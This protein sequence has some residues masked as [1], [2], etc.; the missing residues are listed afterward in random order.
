M[1]SWPSYNEIVKTRS[2]QAFFSLLKTGKSFS[3][4]QIANHLHCSEKTVRNYIKEVNTPDTVILSANGLYY[5]DTAADIEETEKRFSKVT[6]SDAQLYIVQRVLQLP[7]GIDEDELLKELCISQKTLEKYIYDI[8]KSIVSFN[9]SIGHKKG[10]IILKGSENDKRELFKQNLRINDYSYIEKGLA[11]LSNGSNIDYDKLKNILRDCLNRYDIYVNDYSFLNILTHLVVKLVRISCG[12]EIGISDNGIEITEGREYE[13]SRDI[14]SSINENFHMN[15][16]DEEIRQLTVLISSKSIITDF[17]AYRNEFVTELETTK[18]FVMNVISEVEE[19][20]GISLYDDEF[21]YFFMIHVSGLINRSKM[22][23]YSSN[24]LFE[25]V[26]NSDSYIYEIAVFVSSKIIDHYAIEIPNEEIAFIAFHIGSVIVKK[27]LFAERIYLAVQTFDFYHYFDILKSKLDKMTSDSVKISYIDKNSI[28]SPL[29]Y[30]LFVYT[31]LS[32]LPDIAYQEKILINPMIN[33]DSIGVIISKIDTIREEKKK[34][35]IRTYLDQFFSYYLFEK[36]VYFGSREEC[37]H[38]MADKLNAAGIVDDNFEKDVLQREN[39]T[40]TS[41]DSGIALPHAITGTAKNNRAFVI[42]NNKPMP[43]GDY[44]V[45][46][47]IMIA[48]N[49]SG[50][51]GF[52]YILDTL[53]DKVS[54][55]KDIERLRNCQDFISFMEIIKDI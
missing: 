7:E 43:W 36:N 41:F 48:L 31:G 46:I 50:Y 1:F 3:V 12:N 51:K 15:I 38:Y 32:D 17:S 44:D 21:I 24:P 45:S 34:E 33:D 39:I 20:F 25:E 26:L 14:I 13:C 23:K 6:P 16:S 47:I 19:R 27:N 2:F 54:T 9:L 55:E 28:S 53:L 22:G 35:K 52:K 11:H 8:N 37:I 42:I 18:E 49:Y 4:A 29:T 5:L 40:A 30:D 10:K